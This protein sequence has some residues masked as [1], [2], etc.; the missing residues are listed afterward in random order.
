MTAALALVV[1]L[2]CVGAIW[3]A[4]A[5]HRDRALFHAQGRLVDVGGYRLHLYC[6][7][8]GSP[9]V[10]LEAGGGNPW[11]A[12][13]KVQPQ[14]AQF[15]RVCS[16]DRAGLGWSD[17]SPNPPTAKEIATEL[18]TLLA[19]AGI[20]GPYVL[21]GHS[22]GGMYVRMFQSRYP[23]E[24]VGLVLVDSS[25]PDQT[26]RFQ[27]EAKKLSAGSGKALT[28]MQWLR[29]FGVLRLL[30]SR[31][32]PAEIRPQYTAVL[33][34][35]EFIAAVRAES[36]A[37]EENDAEVRPLGSLGDLPLAVLSHDPD[38]VRLPNNLTEP[39]NR[40]W[41]EMQTELSHLST[42][43]THDVV[44]GASHNIELDAPDAVASAI[45]R[46]FYQARA[47]SRPSALD[48]EGATIVNELSQA[49]IGRK[50]TIQG[51]FSL[52][53]K[54]APAY[55]A[56]ADHQA[57]YLPASWRWS[58]TYSEMDGKIVAAT[59]ILRFYHSPDAKPAGNIR[60][61]LPDHFYFQAE[62]TQLRFIIP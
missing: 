29:P 13:Y 45:H 17:A 28:A 51:K 61:R 48:S 18:H 34:R 22:L 20:S 19:N 59:G 53:G 47:N 10:L 27:P 44:K 12:W 52:R 9:T 33:C 57:V 42:R 36:E 58:A 1:V 15:T 14:V 2:A 4:I 25:H 21:V 31:A 6:V 40:A 5:S 43:G 37:V 41:D 56:L 26:A 49:L 35:P 55:V 38:K 62:T 3:E 60:A 50:V 32:A 8:E 39:V 54:I 11:L 23:S 46:V 16:Y 30:A 24:V 7:G